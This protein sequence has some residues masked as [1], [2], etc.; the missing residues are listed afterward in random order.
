MHIHISMID[1]I[2]TFL[3]ILIG[4]FFW[5]LASYNAVNSDNDILQSIGKAMS[6]I[7]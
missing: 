5:R 2:K 3:Y 1:G 6:F 7:L 4:A